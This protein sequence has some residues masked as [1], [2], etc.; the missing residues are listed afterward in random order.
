MRCKVEEEGCRI[1]G[2][3]GWQWRWGT[4]CSVSLGVAVGDGDVFV[5]ISHGKKIEER[6]QWAREEEEQTM[7]CKV[8]EEG[9]KIEGE[10]GAG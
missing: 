4:S 7:R 8:E 9:R 5:A 2:G 6:E 1:E 10:G 3:A